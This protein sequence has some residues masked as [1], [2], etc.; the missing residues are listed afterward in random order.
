MD[1]KFA[2]RSFRKNWGFTLLAVVIMALGIGANTAVFSVVNTVLLRPLAYRDPDRIVTLASPLI[3]GEAP[4]G[5]PK[6]VSIP[7]FQDWHDQ[8][9]SFEAMAFYQTYEAPVMSGPAAE[10]A[11][12]A[13]VSPEFF[14]VF[15]VQP[16]L[17]RF[18]S[19]EEAKPGGSAALLISY[20]YWQSHFGGDADALGRIT[21]VYGA[22]MAVVGVLPPGFQFPAGTDLWYPTDTVFREVTA[23][24]RGAQNYQ[25]VGRLKSGVSVGG[26]QTEISGIA[27]RLAQQYPQTNKNRTAVVT[28]I[29]DELVGDFRVTL[30]LLLGAV[31]AVLLI[32]C[33]NTATLLLGKATART[34]EVSVRAAL[35]AGR[36]RIARQLLT[37]SLLLA[38]FAGGAGL[39]LAYAGSK[40][41]IA[42][43]PSGVPRL[44]E[45]GIDRWVLAFTAGASLV[46]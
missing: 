5:L 40:A 27:A 19:A 13:R 35:G 10:Y 2:L 15:A 33:A 34:R 18:F 41:L 39:C 29:R 12:V 30:Y 7:N 4:V 28:Q 42:L 14:R 45:T 38:T 17:G 8:S 21:R 46:T 25:A 1:L 43:A 36:R 16:M 24:F 32:A 20:A 11:R 6:L 26:A 9:S 22:S 37:E 3:G 23:T 44:A 31:S